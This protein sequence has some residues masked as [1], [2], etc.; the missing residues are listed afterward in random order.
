MTRRLTF[1]SV[2]T[3]LATVACSDNQNTAPTDPA[4]EPAVASSKASS[5][6]VIKF[7]PTEAGDVRAAVEQAG[8]KVSNLFSPA[9]VATAESADPAFAGRLGLAK[10]IKAVAQDTVVQWVDP[11][12]R[13]TVVENAI[14]DTERWFPIQWN[15]RAI[16]AQEAWE[17]EKGDG[18]RVAILDGG[19]WNQHVDIAPNLDAGASRSFVTGI[20]NPFTDTGTFWHGTHVAG[21]VAAAD[22]ADN[23][24]TIG[25]AP[26]ATLIGVKVL[27]NG[28]GSF[29]AIIMGIYYAAT[30]T[31]EGGRADII[32]MS[33]GAQLPSGRD[34]KVRALT[35]LM[36]EAT[37]FAHE[38]G[39][40]IVASAGNGD[41]KG[42]G[43]DHDLGQWFTL[44]AQ[45]SNVV[46]VSAL[47]P[48]GFAL[49]ATNFDR[50]AS[51]SNFGLR[52]VD[53]S[54][55]GGDGALP[56]DALCTMAINPGVPAPTTTTTTQPCWVFDLVVS[57]CRGTGTS[58]VCFAAG[59][60]MSAPAVSGV[61]ALMVDKKNRKIS[62]DDLN[63]ATDDLGRPGTDAIYGQGR[64]NALKAV[65]AP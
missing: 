42:R 4:N 37:D 24:G 59:T 57:S 41:K 46:G 29:G 58:N 19:I 11:N 12:E 14:G 45:A 21:I 40:L 53:L 43:I 6:Y 56:G 3:I 13:F 7:A 44:P 26:E 51:Y 55:P 25:I 18:A 47:G 50:L 22:N 8:G 49:G 9:G 35:A 63:D 17:H 32:N 34:S 48:V 31:I 15:L 62:L 60:S 27:H 5:S 1:L 65:L 30:Q 28:S 54:G 2:I 20:T 64:V 16:K 61:A 23:L 38:R 52:I 39:V 10:G 36:N 33:L